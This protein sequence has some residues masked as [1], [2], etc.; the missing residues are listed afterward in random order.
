MDDV[1][2]PASDAHRLFLREGMTVMSRS[3][4]R[5]KEIS[6]YESEPPGRQRWPGPRCKKKLLGT[7]A[8]EEIASA[9]EENEMSNASPRTY[10]ELF[11]AQER[12]LREYFAAGNVS[13]TAF[14]GVLIAIE[15]LLLRFHESIAGG[16]K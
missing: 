1:E 4:C 9:T 14:Q 15:D 13:L 11:D 16:G 12:L 10:A 7:P 5:R 3:A 6:E 8:D 2:Q